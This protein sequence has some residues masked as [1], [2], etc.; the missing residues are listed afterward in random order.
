MIY[1][2]PFL[3]N[4]RSKEIDY[5]NYYW[6]KNTFTNEEIEKIML[7]REKENPMDISKDRAIK[8]I[9]QAGEKVHFLFLL[10]VLSSLLN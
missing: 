8:K 1:A 5:M 9:K 4:Y 2:E 7:A 3:Q 6:F 10:L